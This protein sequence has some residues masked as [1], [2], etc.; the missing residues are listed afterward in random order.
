M[1]AKIEATH[2]AAGTVLS[3][4]RASL[5]GRVIG[6]DDVGYDEARTVFY[7]GIDR[8]PA[9]IVRPSDASEVALVVSLAREAGLELAIR[10]GGHSLAGHSVSD[11]GIVLDLANLRTLQIDTEHGTAWAETGLTT[12]DYTVAAAAH[13]LATGF[14]DTASVGLGGLTLGG[15]MGYLVRK[16]GLTIDNLLAAEIVTADGQLRRADAQTHPDLFWAIRG[17]GGNFGVATRFQFQLHPVETVVGGMLLLP[18]TA[19]TIAEFVAEAET[20]PDELSTIVNV[21]PAPPLPFVPSQYHGRLIIMATLCYAGAVEAGLR[22]VA[23]LRAL[24]TPVADLIRPTRYPELFPP[25]QPQFHPTVVARQMFVEQIDRATA[26]TILE[27]LGASDARVRVA[28]IRVQGGAMARVPA[29]ATA[30]THRNARILVNVAAFY[31]GPENR[32]MRQGW[33]EDF[34]ATLY[35]GDSAATVNFLGNEG[36][37]RVR[38]AY[39]GAA[40]DRLVEIKTRY[41]PAN[42]FRLNQ[43][44]PPANGHRRK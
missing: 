34:A 36:P 21:M 4:L 44:I 32:A 30:F 43:N 5:K 37:E 14:G 42:L 16:H 11:G 15:G 6:P 9:A 10:S 23:P 19:D 25:D 22:A 38:D 20:A 24:A 8:G 3:D 31:D 7:G 39:P 33:V 17:G 29:E 28:Q 12:G 1:T 27:Y 40:W 2:K 18:A 26:Q 41:D 13:G 35:Q